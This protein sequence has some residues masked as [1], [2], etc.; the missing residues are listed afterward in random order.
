M[1]KNARSNQPV[2][3][4]LFLFMLMLCQCCHG[5]ADI[6]LPL[7]QWKPLRVVESGG[8]L[9]ER[10]DGWRKNRLWHMADTSW[11]LS[12]FDSRPGSHAWQGEH[13]GK[14]LHAAVMAQ[15]ATRDEALK[16]ELDAKVDDLLA[17]QLPNGYL[18]T[19]IEEDRFYAD[20][21]APRGWDVWTH[22]YNLYGLLTYEQFHPNEKVVDACKKMADLL[23]EVFGPGKNDITAYGTRKG[24]SSTCLIESMVMLYGRTGE[25]KYLDF[26]QQIVTWS[27]NNH[28]LRLMD[29]MLNRESV[30]HP[31]EGKAYQLMANLLGYYQLFLHTG[32]EEYLQTVVHGWE[33]IRENHLLVTGG[34]WTRKMPYN[35]NAECFAR[36]ADFEPELV[37]VENCCTVTWIQLNL[38]LFGLTGLASYY[39]EAER[40]FYN[41]LLGGQHA[42]G[43]DWC[44]FT[45]P[46][47]PLRPFDSRI[48]CCAS[49]GPRALEM[50]ARYQVGEMGNQLCIS[51]FAP[52]RYV[53]PEKFGDGTLNIMGRFPYPTGIEIEFETIR[54]EKFTLAFR[55][56]SGTLLTGME[57]NGKNLSPVKNDKDFYQVRYKWQ[58][59]DILRIKLKN[60]L[61]LHA[62]TGLDDR[63]WVAFSY[64]PMVL[65]Q[66]I[67]ADKE[68]EEP[69]H[70]QDL[71]N[72]D[73]PKVL[74]K[75][76][77]PGLK[78][79]DLAF[80]IVGTDITL[81]P[82]YLAGSRKSGPRTYFESIP[83]K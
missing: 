54:A 61:K 31:G 34:P 12:G 32:N 42:N 50:F 4:L 37:R 33:D 45:R 35:G 52:S 16:R 56:P 58:P 5:P 7:I 73:I 51:G 14:W 53:L 26:A 39:D 17:A 57:I 10:V 22:R 63:Q 48:S 71:T 62:L 21:D 46:N 64:G 75:L 11:L 49:S 67:N 83:G 43:M 65:S 68:V 29:A 19:Y 66:E 8:L 41:Q 24:I 13:M 79:T 59:G 27:E 77:H 55:T 74:E 60:E 15:Y 9:G 6:E 69:F 70:D 80:G 23:I 1:K 72:G 76:V 44:Y 3:P 2:Q 81:I 47:E 18:G 78:A 20:P 40:A 36:P 25:I 30:V 82:Y 38:H 28:D